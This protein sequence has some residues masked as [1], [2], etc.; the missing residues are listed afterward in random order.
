MG[1]GW[2]L[3][4]EARGDRETRDVTTGRCRVGGPKSS[5]RPELVGLLAAAK[6][7]DVSTR[8]TMYTD[9]MSA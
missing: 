9:S 4:H 3:L 6:A 5:L 8:L 7:A 2:I 1:A